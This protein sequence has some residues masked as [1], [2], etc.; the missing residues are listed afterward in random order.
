MASPS[1]L[2][3]KAAAWIFSTSRG[4]WSGLMEMSSSS[5]LI[6]ISHISISASLNCGLSTTS[7]RISTVGSKP[8]LSTLAA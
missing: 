8:R 7:P 2:F 6:V 3:L 1:V 5:Y 4:S